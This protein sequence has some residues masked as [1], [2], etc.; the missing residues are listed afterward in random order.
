MIES[1]SFL[2]LRERR[3]EVQSWKDRIKFVGRLVLR[4]WGVVDFYLGWA[5]GG[6]L[7]G[8][9]RAVARSI[10]L[11]FTNTLGQE[12]ISISFVSFLLILFILL[13]LLNS[14]NIYKYL[15]TDLLGT[16]Y[17]E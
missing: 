7:Y 12:F 3:G 11:L 10:A 6:T 15:S 2:F 13:P 5:S 4:V 8:I 17:E 16:V 1:T 9:L 14:F